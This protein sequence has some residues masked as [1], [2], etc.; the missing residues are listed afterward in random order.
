ML[1]QGTFVGQHQL[2][3]GD[4]G[5]CCFLQ[6]FLCAVEGIRNLCCL[7]VKWSVSGFRGGSLRVGE[8]KTAA[9]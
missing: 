8:D 9:N 7:T 6:Q 2:R 3:D 1:D 4:V 5:G